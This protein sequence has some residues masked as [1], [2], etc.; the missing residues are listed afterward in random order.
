MK[1]VL[2]AVNLSFGYE[3]DRCCLRGISLQLHEGEC[4]GIVGGNGA[5]KSTL[6]WC[7]LGLLR[8]SGTVRLLGR[9][10]DRQS[11][12][13]VGV[14]FQN[15]EDQLF[16]PSLVQDITLPL[17]N[18]G[19]PQEQA[20]EL[21]M[22]ALALI[23]LQELAGR[24]ALHLSLG[25]RKRASI[26]AA[27]AGAPHLLILDEPTAELDGRAVRQ[28]TEILQRLPVARLVTSHNL[29]FLRSLAAR[30]AVLNRG[31]IVAEGSTHDIL[32]NRP[33]LL[34]AGLI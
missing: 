19:M 18:R 13:E 5:G 26:A 4:L 10:P 23:N 30:V 6:I 24:Q 25:E 12:E 29:D 33:L 16:M 1:T 17:L 15:P 31:T 3:R 2:E 14:V 9:A 27:L 8:A 21:A 34:E 20:K 32:S 11:L 28:L 22:Q 7:L